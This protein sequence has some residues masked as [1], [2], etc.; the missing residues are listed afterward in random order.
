MNSLNEIIQVDWERRM[1]S[2]PERASSM[3]DRR[4]DDQWTDYSLEAIEKRYREIES[5]LQMLNRIDIGVLSDEERLNHDL[6]KLELETELEGEQYRLYLMPLNQRRGPQSL[7][8]MAGY[9]RLETEQDFENWLARLDKLPVLVDQHIELLR[10]GMRSGVMLPKIV[11][12]RVPAQIEKQVVSSPEESPFFAAFNK[13]PSDELREKARTIIG[14]NVLPAMQKFQRFFV[15]EH[16]PACPDEVGFSHLPNGEAIYAYLARL[17]TTTNLTPD[18]I[19]E[20]GLSEVARITEEMEQCKD[21]TGFAGDMASFFAFL[22]SDP[23]F[24][25]KTGQELL[26]AYRAM[27]KKIDPELVRLFRTLPRTPYGVEPIPMNIAPDTTTAYYRPAAADGSR[28]GSYFVNLYKPESRPK[29]EMMALSLHEAVPGHHLQIALAMEQTHLP[30]FRRHA[31][32]N[33]YLEGWA[34]SAEKLGEEMGLYE[35]EYSRFGRLTYEM[36]RSV[37]LVVDTG[38]HVKGWSREKAIEYFMQK[39]A[40]TELDVVN[41]IDR[42][43]AWPGQALAYKIGEIKMQAIRAKCEKALGD[44]FDIK[45]YHDAILLDGAM[46]LNALERKIDRWLSNPV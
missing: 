24:F 46:P 45:A 10:E 31:Y 9:L 27:S 40:K 28:A 14:Q 29:W 34:L 32:F 25:Y 8:D 37:R 1:R 26:D 22:R 3:G 16:L 33:G 11:L 23:Q 19:H 5:Y 7:D 21:R 2:N 12:S 39:A 20:I 38:M 41:E 4:Y 30:N 36:W 44:R 43:I 15:D 42:Y 13:A 18:Q 17:H 6:L 35:D